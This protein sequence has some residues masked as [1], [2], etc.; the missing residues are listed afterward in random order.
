MDVHNIN[1]LDLLLGGTVIVSAIVGLFRGLI[2]EMLSLLAWVLALWLAHLFAESLAEQIVRQ[3]IPDKL[4]SYIASF[5]GIFL[6]ALFAIGLLNLL[7]SSVLESVGLTSFDRTLGMLFGLAR[8][9]VLSALFVFFAAFI[10]PLRQESFWQRSHL[11]PS[12]MNL[13]NWGVARLPQ[14]IRALVGNHGYSQLK[15]SRETITK[16]P[17][18]QLE[19]AIAIELESLQGGAFNGQARRPTIDARQEAMQ[20]AH[21][22]ALSDF[23][24]DG[25]IALESLQSSAPKSKTARPTLDARQQAIQSAQNNALSDS[26]KDSSLSLESLQN[27]GEDNDAPIDDR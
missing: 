10:T 13:A 23:G 6:A 14:N 4:I 7:I 19:N 5:G 3:F 25:G 1:W 9:A 20:S 16:T 17:G 27:G 2:K 26:G 8:G 24:T 22:N 21:S 11:A 15:P 18:E 12:F